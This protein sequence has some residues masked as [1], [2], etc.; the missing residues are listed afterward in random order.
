MHAGTQTHV[1][2]EHGRKHTTADELGGQVADVSC[3]VKKVQRTTYRGWR[4]QETSGACHSR[5]Q[6]AKTAWYGKVGSQ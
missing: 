5:Q 3:V 2:M 4:Y 1:S 6:E